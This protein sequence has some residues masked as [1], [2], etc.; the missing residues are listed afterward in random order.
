[1]FRKYLKTA[2]T[3]YSERIYEINNLPLPST[4]PPPGNEQAVCGEM[5][6]AMLFIKREKELLIYLTS[7][8][9]QLSRGR[10]DQ[11]NIRQ[12]F[13]MIILFSHFY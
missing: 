12:P 13:K 11:W 6:T 1:M 10:V 4:S 2:Q 7:W 9:G 3:L 8:N 5:S